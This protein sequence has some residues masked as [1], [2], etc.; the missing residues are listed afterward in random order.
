MPIPPA[1]DGEGNTA[2]T[3][4]RSW[5][6]TE[7]VAVL[8]S[9]EAQAAHRPLVCFEEDGTGADLQENTPPVSASD[10]LPPGFRTDQTSTIAQQEDPND[11]GDWEQDVELTAPPD[12]PSCTNLAASLHDQLSRHLVIDLDEGWD[13]VEIALPEALYFAGKRPAAEHQQALRQ[14]LIQA[15]RDGRVGEERVADAL[16]AISN[17]GLIEAQD[18]SAN[19]LTVLNDLPVIRDD[20]P[21]APDPIV[22]VA[23]VEEAEHG[24]TASAALAHF[25]SLQSNDT[26]PFSQYLKSLP[27]DRLTR[28]DEMRLG[29]MIEESS[30]EILAAITACSRV[31]SILLDDAQS[32][33]R[34]EK[35][36]REMFDTAKGEEVGTG[37]KAEETNEKD[38]EGDCAATVSPPVAIV[39]TLNGIIEGCR[40]A[41]VD[42]SKLA[43]ALY[44]AELSENYLTGLQEAAANS[45]PT[46]QLAARI[47]AA[48]VKA[49]AG[50]VRLVTANLRLVIWVARRYGALT[51]M[52]R[53]QE[54]NIGLMRAARRFDH[55]RGTKFS[56]YAIWWIRQSISRATADMA[57]TIRIP[58]HVR[59]NLRKVEKAK[60]R[61]FAEM[62]VE[63]DPQR[64]A[65]LTE[66][67]V[68]QV[69]KL[70]RVPDEPSS[71]DTDIASTIESYPDEATPS[72]EDKLIA[73]EVRTLVRRHL[74]ILDQ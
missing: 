61:T 27:A 52:D 57:R 22:A 31:V 16:A 15:L 39:A 35:A 65:V 26:D 69:L 62:G 72:A 45:D 10:A 14:L 28:A 54:G 9:I 48:H 20:E 1:V 13:D 30:L 50:R 68:Q 43:A 37:Y 29:E 42:R 59:D 58:V 66:L 19:L 24:D 67:P 71:I 70:L 32:I 38:E 64:I 56:T 55:R 47:R 40:L 73:E 4:A 18:W 17:E 8:A 60:I 63:L 23:D 5:G 33:L 49:E 25:W 74:G 21:D 46:G 2:V 53:I 12:D 3:I 11:V 6:H 34:G 51:L 7:L 44:F 36:V 41:S